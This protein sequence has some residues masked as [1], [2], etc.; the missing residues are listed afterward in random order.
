[1][2]HVSTVSSLLA[3]LFDD[4]SLFPPAELSLADAITGHLRHQAAWYR[5]ISG[6]FACTGARLGALSAAL[7]VANLPEIDLA[8]IVTGGPSAAGPAI[9]QVATDPRLRLRSV[10]IPARPPAGGAGAAGAAG[11]SG[12]RDAVRAVLAALDAVPL[13]GARGYVEIPLAACEPEILSLI[14]A[15][16]A[17]PKL[18]TGGADAAAFP[19][20]AEL[21]AALVALADHRLAFKCTAGLHN[22]VRHTDEATGFVHHGFLNLLLATAAAADGADPAAVADLLASQDSA[23]LAARAAGLSLITADLARDL[24]TSIGT[25]STDEPVADLVALGLLSRP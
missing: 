3:G 13:A 20:V 25:C 24:L 4:A 22:A 1:V 11:T 17:R 23:G 21:A 19:G 7:T 18:R 9:D 15:G 2:A 8:L 16:G 6:A 5:D 14:E 12:V 10:E